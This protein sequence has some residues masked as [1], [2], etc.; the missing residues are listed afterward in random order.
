[1]GIGATDEVHILGSMSLVNVAYATTLGW[2]NPVLERLET[3]ALIPMFGEEPVELGLSGISESELL[4]RFK[5]HSDYPTRFSDAFP[6]EMEP[7]SVLNIAKAISS[8]I[9]TLISFE[10]PYDQYTRGDEE[11]LF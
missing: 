8:F 9:R 1:M 2:A 11:A 6:G 4:A 3:Q 10:S 7:I 5:D